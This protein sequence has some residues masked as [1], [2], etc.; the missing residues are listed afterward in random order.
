MVIMGE[1][2]RRKKITKETNIYD[3]TKHKP[4]K[5]RK[6]VPQGV[7]NK[8]KDEIRRSHAIARKKRRRIIRVSLFFFFVIAI[9]FS[10]V[11]GLSQAF[12]RVDTISVKYTNKASSSKRYYTSDEIVLSSGITK[13]KN[14][15]LLSGNNAAEKI[16]TLRPYISKANVKRDFP[17]GVVIEVTECK[18]VYAFKSSVGYVLTD[19]NGKYLEIADS[20]KAEK[21]MIVSSKN[22]TATDIGSS[23]VLTD[24]DN[25]DK[26][27]DITD[28]VFEYL[29]LLRK[30]GLNITKADF[31]DIDDIYLEYDNRIE[32]HI[33]KPSDE[34]NG[35]TAWK[36]IQL[37][38]KSLEAEDKQNPTQKGTLN[39][40]I[41]KKA[42]FKQ[43]SDIPETT[44][45]IENS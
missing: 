22:V 42:Y 1:K 27:R 15:L 41:A 23:V 33:G 3:I 24:G 10:L 26:S 18:Q 40:T 7:K 37:A 6:Q 32:I 43:T 29:T 20:K 12:C 44:K 36:K 5:R 4:L 9:L 39:M 28:T 25:D 13:G 35:V 38:K 16:E 21:Y 17:S 45:P 34:K 14:L 30:S 2:K 19:E 8:S 31:T 11:I